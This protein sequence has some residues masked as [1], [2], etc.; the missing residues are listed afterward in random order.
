[1]YRKKNNENLYKYCNT[2]LL[3]EYKSRYLIIYPEKN[4]PFSIRRVNHNEGN[5]KTI[6][7]NSSY[8]NFIQ[9]LNYELF[10]FTD[11]K[12]DNNFYVKVQ[13]HSILGE[14]NFRHFLINKNLND[15]YELKDE[16]NISLNYTYILIDMEKY[17][18]FSTEQIF[19]SGQ[20]SLIIELFSY[21]NKNYTIERTI[22]ND[23]P[24]E[25]C[26]ISRNVEKEITKIQ[27]RN[28]F[29]QFNLNEIKN[30]ERIII[31]F[32]GLNSVFREK[33][34]FIRKNRIQ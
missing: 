34:Y 26:N 6:P 15:I 18:Y 2:S 8:S 27:N 19:K 32:E 33:K 3:P 28:L 23:I 9:G 1:M 29:I 14:E 7:I 20:Q 17:Y 31:K 21:G 11:S 30:D 5:I 10:G 24:N 13:I 12:Y 4:S 22:T 16:K 25:F